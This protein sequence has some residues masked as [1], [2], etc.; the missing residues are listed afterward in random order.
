VPG[1]FAKISRFQSPWIVCGT[2]DL[3]F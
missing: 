3:V 1:A 2:A